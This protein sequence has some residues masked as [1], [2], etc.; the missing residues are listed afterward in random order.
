MYLSFAEQAQ[1]FHGF[2]FPRHYKR[3]VRRAGA[4]DSAE[5]AACTLNGAGRGGRA[6]LRDYSRRH[7]AESVIEKPWIHGYDNERERVD[8]NLVN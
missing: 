2:A 3:R 5:V 4:L 8:I 6:G 1:L 7:T